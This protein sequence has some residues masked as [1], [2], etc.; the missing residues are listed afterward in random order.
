MCNLLHSSLTPFLSKSV[1]VFPALGVVLHAEAL[2]AVAEVVVEEE[3]LVMTGVLIEA[4]ISR[5][6]VEAVVLE[7]AGRVVLSETE[8][9]GAVVVAATQTLDMVGDLVH[10]TVL[11]T[12]LKSAFPKT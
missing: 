3:V 8:V 1:L 12:K 11:R 5:G 10:P 2:A 4:L 7:E 6:V 9:M